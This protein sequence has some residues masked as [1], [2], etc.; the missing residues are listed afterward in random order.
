MNRFLIVLLFCICIVFTPVHSQ[1]SLSL[2]SITVDKN[3][4]FTVDVPIS[5]EQGKSI[6]SFNVTL[7]FNPQVVSLIAANAD[8]SSVIPCDSLLQKSQYT[9]PNTMQILL[10]CNSAFVGAT[11]QTIRLSF[12]AL[13][14]KDSQTVVEVESI[15]EN[16]QNQP[17]STPISGTVTIRDN[18]QVVQNFPEFLGQNYPN[19][20]SVDTDNPYTTTF[21]Y[22]INNQTDI[23][24]S[25]YNSKGQ[26]ILTFPTLQRD[27][28][29]FTFV[30]GMDPTQFSSGTYSLQMETNE[31]VYFQSFLFLK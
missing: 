29:E 8:G 21:P 26:K 10:G 23:I 1:I 7:K 27:R 18:K 20:V 9:P 11:N 31:G 3:E 12:L 25:V 30:L 16:G 15:S 5:F 14:G 13:A 4:R 2:P 28:G 17:I 19:P 6:D 22:S 24:F